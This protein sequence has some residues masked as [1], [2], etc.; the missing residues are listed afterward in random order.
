M[1]TVLVKSKILHRKKFKELIQ[2]G[3][4]FDDFES[5]DNKKT[6]PE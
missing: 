4:K 6:Y 3:K 5:D 2:S 1:E